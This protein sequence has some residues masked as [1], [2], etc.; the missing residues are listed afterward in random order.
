MED[1]NQWQPIETA[2]KDEQTVL[3]F[4]KDYGIVTVKWRYDDCWGGVWGNEVYIQD[5]SIYDD[6]LIA[7]NPT[8][9]MSLTQPPATPAEGRNEL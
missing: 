8:H 5:G 4:D 1:D 6:A 9:W 3:V 7:R 2:P